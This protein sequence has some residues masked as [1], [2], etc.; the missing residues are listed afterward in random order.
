MVESPEAILAGGGPPRARD[1][2]L[3]PEHN[4][5]IQAV[6]QQVVHSHYQNGLK[7]KIPALGGKTPKQAVKDPDSR[8][9][10]EALLTQLERDME[11]QY[12]WMKD[13]PVPKLRA[14]L[15]LEKG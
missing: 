1:P 11:C 13:S 4:T 9:M 5:D 15:G 14:R 12:P 10:V 3:D 6:I 7:E 8:E 2:A